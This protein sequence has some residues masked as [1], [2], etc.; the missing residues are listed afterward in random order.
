MPDFV[1]K[2]FNCKG[3]MVHKKNT[4]ISRGAIKTPSQDDDG[5]YTE[6]RDVHRALIDAVCLRTNHKIYDT[7]INL[8][9]STN[10]FYFSMVNTSTHR[11]PPTMLPKGKDF[12]VW[13]PRKETQTEP[14]QSL[15]SPTKYTSKPCP[16]GHTM[17]RSSAFSTRSDQERCSSKAHHVLWYG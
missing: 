1:T 14:S 2:G 16:A 12:K 13:R 4:T 6:L 11:S 17:T 15:K 8:L 7:Y 9:Y 10:N 5:P 3:E